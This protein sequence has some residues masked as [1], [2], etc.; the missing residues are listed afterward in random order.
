M[1]SGFNPTYARDDR[2][3][4]VLVTDPGKD[5]D[6]EQ[7][8]VF[9]AGLCRAGMV[10]LKAVVAN[11]E[12]ATE[13]AKLAK[14]TLIQLG[15]SHVPVGIG[16]GVFHGGQTHKYE[17]DVEYANSVGV[18]ELCDGCQLLSESLEDSADRSITLIVIS[19]MTDVAEL[20]MRHSELFVS[21]VKEVV[22]MGGV[23]YGEFLNG[24]DGMNY[25]S[26]DDAANNSFDWPAAL[27][28]YQS[29][30][31]W[32][33]PVTIV[34]RWAAYG[35]K[36]PFPL[37]ERFG[38]TGNPIGQSLLRRQKPAINQLWRSATAPPGCSTRG[39]LP[40][41]RDR[42]WFVDVFC[43]GL[44]PGIGSEEDIWPFCGSYNQSDSVAVA[45]A[46]GELRER[47]FSPSFVDVRGVRHQI[48][49]LR[50]TQA[51]VKDE[52]GLREFICQTQLATLAAGSFQ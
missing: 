26:P 28:V 7:A 47:F 22:I 37:F 11:L 51:G 39:R 3:D 43:D 46:I 9:L 18:D 10:R 35:V 30:Q 20:M 29:L 42:Q 34:T 21:R 4:V 45:A 19:G 48:V 27:Y 24:P 1:E 50:D 15:L 31:E 23:R 40:L 5:L 25:L 6:D 38:A 32:R 33:I 12:P 16:R 2:I 41:S 49:G 44:D 8:L 36:F 13:R 52:S 17:T 14:G